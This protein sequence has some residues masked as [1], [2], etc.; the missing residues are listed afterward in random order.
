MLEDLQIKVSNTAP[1]LEQSMKR[2]GG[3][4]LH[5]DATHEKDAP[6][7]MTGMDGL[8][9]IVL[10]NVK[11]PSEHAD[12]I[13]P[14]LQQL[15]DNYGTPVACV[16][17][18]GTGIC[19]AVSK[20]FPGILDFICHFHFLRDTGKDLLDPSYGQLRKNLRKYAAT[21]KLNEI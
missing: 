16:H 9:Q 11:I 8:K 19:K 5:L 13:I 1:C 14:F 20:V 15:Q 3:Y 2:S 4:I 6:A 18:M 12:H 21:T 7:L 17:D 10:A